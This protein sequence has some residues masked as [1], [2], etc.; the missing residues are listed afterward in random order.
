MARRISDRETNACTAPDKTNPST[1]AH[2][3]AQNMKNAS[4]NPCQTPTNTPTS[5]P[6][7][8]TAP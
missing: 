7:K 2:S 8:T 4:S 3:V 5:Y 1:R 6:F